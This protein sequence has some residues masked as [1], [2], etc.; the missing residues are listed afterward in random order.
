M[1]FRELT[2]WQKAV[3]LTVE[4]YRLAKRLPKE[5]LYYLSS[6]MRRAAV[7]IPSNIAEGQSRKSSKEFT[8]FLSIA[9]GSKSELETQLLICNRLNYLTKDDTAPAMEL[10]TEISKMITALAQKLTTNH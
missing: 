7:S 2:V 6:Q 4:V 5:E 1:S 3:D 8:N 9:Q 10:L